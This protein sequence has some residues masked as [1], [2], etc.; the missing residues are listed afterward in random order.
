MFPLFLYVES[1]GK[2]FTIDSHAIEI[3]VFESFIGA[4]ISIY[5]L[6]SLERQSSSK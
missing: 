4:D 1:R 2:S 3:I 6:N 5:N